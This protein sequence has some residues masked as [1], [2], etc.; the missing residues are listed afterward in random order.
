LS[1]V[2]AVVAGNNSGVRLHLRV[3]VDLQK[4]VIDAHHHE[5][6]VGCIGCIV[7]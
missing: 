3:K 1:V 6:V 4:V 5:V 2:D 7:Q